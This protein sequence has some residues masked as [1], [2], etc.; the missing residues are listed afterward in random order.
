MQYLQ[1]KMHPGKFIFQN[2]KNL[3]KENKIYH[4]LFLTCTTYSYKNQI[5]L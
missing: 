3:T 5:T 4:F 1:A 2:V